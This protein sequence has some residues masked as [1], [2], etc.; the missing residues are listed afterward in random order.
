MLSFIETHPHLVEELHPKFNDGVDFS[1]LSVYST[2]K[3][4]WLGKCGHEWQAIVSN[5]TKDKPTGCPVCAGKIILP[6]YNDFKSQEPELLKEWNYN[7]NTIDPSEISSKSTKNVWWLGKC[8]HEWETSI[9]SRAVRKSVCPFC[10]GRQVLEGFNDL[11]TTHPNI[12]SEWHPTKNGSIL[13][14][15]FSA[16]SNKK[17]WWQDSFGHEWEASIDK[18]A[19]YSRGCPFCSGNKV[20]QG[21]NDLKTTHSYLLKE[22]DPNLNSHIDISDISFGSNERIVWKCSLGHN[23]KVSISSRVVYQTGCPTCSNK[24]ISKGYNDLESLYPQLAKE[25]HPTKNGTLLPTEISVGSNKRIWW[26]CEKKHEWESTPCN[27]I[28]NGYG[29]PRCSHLVSKAEN[30]ISD[31]LRSKGLTVKQSDRKVL[32]GKELDIYL[33]EKNIAIEF[34]GIYW[35]CELYKDKNYHYDKWL[36]CKQKGIQLIQIWEDEWQ[37]NPKLVESILLHKIN[38]SESSNTKI[39]ARK[40]T[41]VKVE[42]DNAKIF[43]NK[44]HI[45]GFSSASYYYGLEHHGSLY[46]V[47]ALRKEKDGILNIIRYATSQSIPGGFSKLITFAERTLKPEAFITF[48]DNCISDGGLY[49]NNGFIMDKELP[50]DYKY[51]WRGKRKHKFGYRLKKFKDDPN[52]VWEDG[53]TERELA[54]LNKIYRIWDAGKIRWIK[55]I[56]KT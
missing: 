5:R 34:N 20:L 12:A 9:N 21:Y 19:L 54:A 17:F 31:L 51:I 41:V 50:P 43:L 22:I 13:P 47:I 49:S 16:G 10:A 25:W 37:S 2:K 29:C 26:Q 1:L 33:P 45:Q 28:S 40:S 3:I 39:Y 55:R 23:W 24:K 53:L 14:S 30:Y 27:R 32:K 52:L 8:G 6:G 7:K 38:I 42:K 44:N 11:V 18:R 46:A 48:S 35:H 36:E 4:W 15:E 56:V